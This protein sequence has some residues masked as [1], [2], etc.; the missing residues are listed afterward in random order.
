MPT[1]VNNG[2]SYF[3][4]KFKD[5]S[6]VHSQYTTMTELHDTIEGAELAGKSVNRNDVFYIVRFVEY[7]YEKEVPGGD[8]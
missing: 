8:E 3:A 2:K 5:G 6:F 1:L 7:S 4:A